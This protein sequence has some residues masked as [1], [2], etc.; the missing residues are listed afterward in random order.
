MQ[1]VKAIKQV[2]GVSFTDVILAAI[3][4][5]F[6]E[7]ISKNSTTDVMYNAIAT[8]KVPEA[9]K[10][11]ILPQQNNETSLICENVVYYSVR[12]LPICKNIKVLERLNLVKHQGGFLKCSYQIIVDY[13]IFNFLFSTFSDVI[14]KRILNCSRI[15][16]VI[17]NLPAPLKTTFFSDNVLEDLVMWSISKVSTDAGISIVISTYINYKFQ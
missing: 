2:S 16:A 12:H 8:P 17:T 7:Y 1:L 9:T 3:S 13:Y 14:L 15:T 5:S 4:S 10:L 6:S 11:L